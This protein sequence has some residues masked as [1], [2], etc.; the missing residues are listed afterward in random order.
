MI[1][2]RWSINIEMKFLV[3]EHLVTRSKVIKAKGI[4]IGFVFVGLR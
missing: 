4:N 1:T 2:K 3:I